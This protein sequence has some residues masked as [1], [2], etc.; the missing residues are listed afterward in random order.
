MSSPTLPTPVPEATPAAPIPSATP[1]APIPVATPAILNPPATSTVPIPPATPATPVKT[2]DLNPSTP[3]SRTN[4]MQCSDNP[5]DFNLV[6]IHTAKCSVCDKRNAT[7]EMRRCKGC[8]WQICRPCQ[9]TREQKGRTLA[10]G[11]LM[12]VTPNSSRRSTMLPASAMTPKK[13]IDAEAALKKVKEEDS[14]ESAMKGSAKKEST[15][16]ESVTK[17]KK[18]A[19]AQAGDAMTPPS[20]TERKNLRRKSKAQTNYAEPDDDFEEDHSPVRKAQTPIGG[21]GSGKRKMAGSPSPANDESPTS[22][23]TRKDCSIGLQGLPPIRLPPKMSEEE[24]KNMNSN[25]KQGLNH[26]HVMDSMFNHFKEGQA[27]LKPNLYSYT[28][29]PQSTYAKVPAPVQPKPYVPNGGPRPSGEEFMEIIRPKVRAK[30]AQRKGW[31]YELPAG[32]S[33]RTPAWSMEY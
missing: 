13:D 21:L 18:K 24:K 22:K 33:R 26:H 32:V 7:D 1:A 6:K 29:A 28:P 10:H 27:M 23:R 5:A 4:R 15:A 12:T 9:I 19:A 14:K 25:D 8:T 3:R 11:N 2:A 20:S 30:L 16:K 17:K 31:P